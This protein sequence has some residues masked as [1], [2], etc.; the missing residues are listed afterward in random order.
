[1]CALVL[2]LFLAAFAAAAHGDYQNDREFMQW[3]STYHYGESDPGKMYSS[4]KKN[5]EFIKQH[6]AGGHSYTLSLNQFAHLVS[7]F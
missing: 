2:L 4:W 3:L 5:A 7:T 6:N 1:M